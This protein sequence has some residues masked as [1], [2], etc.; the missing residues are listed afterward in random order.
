[1]PD[2]HSEP[3]IEQQEMTT[4][5]TSA[6]RY[7]VG[8]S[9]GRSNATSSAPGVAEAVGHQEVPE[10]EK[11]AAVAEPLLMRAADEA[12]LRRVARRRTREDVQR[13]ERVDV[14][15]SVA[16]KRKI[17]AKAASMNIAGA[18]LVG[19]SVMAYL[20]GELTL[21]GQRTPLDDYID[22]LTALRTEVARVGHNVNQI[23][24]KLNSGGHPH[25][26]DASTLVQAER[27][28]TTAGTTVRHIAAAANQAAAGKAAG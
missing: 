14:R 6:A 23:A 3:V 22:E 27:T 17:L 25:P 2:Q 4:T 13:K 10:K 11:P 8:P 21:P 7:G 16:E 9:K 28:L 26:G 5:A 24:R 19:G 15:Y 1:M 18:H 12:A 20:D